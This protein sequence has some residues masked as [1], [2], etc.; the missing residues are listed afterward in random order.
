MKRALSLIALLLA[1][2]M[3]VMCFAA[4]DGDSKSDSSSDD[5]S[6][7]ASTTSSGDVSDPVDVDT[8]ASADGTYEL[9]EYIE[10][11]EDYTEELIEYY[12]EEGI[13]TTIVIDGDTATLFGDEIV[14]QDGVL[15]DPEGDETFTIQG[16]QIIVVEDDSRAVFQKV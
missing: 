11:G 3:I 6:S 4:C 9:V 16:D 8:D 2:M 12:A 14:N 1:A 7:T 5:S 13:P 10:D 15:S